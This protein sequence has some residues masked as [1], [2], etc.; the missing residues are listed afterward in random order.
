[1]QIGDVAKGYVK[2]LGGAVALV[3]T[4]FACFQPFLLGVMGLVWWATH[5]LT[6]DCTLMDE[7]QDA[8]VGL[9][10]ES[11]LAG[12]DA[13]AK[14]AL[15][16]ERPDELDADPHRMDA[17]LLGPSRPWWKIWGNEGSRRPHS[18]GVW[19]IYFAL[20]SL[21]IFGV[22]QWLVPAVD[23]GRRSGLLIYATAYIASA[24]GLL[25]STS[26]LNL[27]RYLRKRRIP[28]PSAMTATW[29]TT[30]GLVIVG[31]T[32][33]SAA[34]LPAIG[35]VR[36]ITGSAVSSSDRRA[37]RWAM[38]QDNG[39]QGDGAQS[40]GRAASKSDGPRDESGGEQ[41]SGK[42]ND[43]DAS[44]R[45]GG[46]GRE[47]GK[48]Q[49]GNAKSGTS[50]G[51]AT[52]SDRGNASGKQGKQSDSAKDA[53]K[54][55]GKPDTRSE[56]HQQKGG[57]EG[58]DQDSAKDRGSSDEQGQDQGSNSPSNAPT[59]SFQAPGWLRI[60]IL[61]VG[62][63]FLLYGAFRYGPELL[64]GF[65]AFL[66]ALLGGL[67]FGSPRED[68]RREEDEATDQRIEPPRPFSSFPNPFDV[69]MD[70]QFAPNDLIVYSFQALEAWAFE[71]G[72]GRLPHETPTEFTRKLGVVQ[73]DLNSEANRLAAIYVRIVYGGRVVKSESLQHLRVFWRTLEAQ[74]VIGAGR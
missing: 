52:S 45:T 50:K 44:K 20:A 29:L 46:K 32:V 57:V 30:G 68:R 38:L 2:D 6:Y 37:S 18:P 24:M 12:E 72:M 51:K 59:L 53:G 17:S 4:S 61:I 60:P 47:G 34:L 49:A 23:E 55:Q 8:G 42:T 36:S 3:S 48:N 15:A 25:L 19:L 58:D 74:G 73:D 27:R 10:Q 39:V 70:R 54:S 14:S 5:H 66:A 71:A 33:L 31:L 64:R 9:L 16:A 1:M 65:M 40:E 21:P 56:D 43:P 22:G 13:A 28:M 63:C 11:G 69:G 35:G 41:G 62:G 7:N 67:W 26:F